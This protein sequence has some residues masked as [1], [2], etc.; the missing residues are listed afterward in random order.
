MHIADVLE[1]VYSTACYHVIVGVVPLLEQSAGG[2]QPGKWLIGCF[3]RYSKNGWMF[4]IE[5]R[6]YYGL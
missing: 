4:A 3:Q 6:S 1:S 2:L 5:R